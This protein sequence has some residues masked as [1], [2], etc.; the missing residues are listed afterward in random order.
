[1][2]FKK[3]SKDPEPEWKRRAAAARDV[4]RGAST[5]PKTERRLDQLEKALTNAADD[6]ERLR[7]AL[8]KM[9]PQRVT[10]ELK[11]ALR[12]RPTPTTPDDKL[13]TSL[14]RR[15]EAINTLQNREEVLGDLIESTLIDLETLAAGSVELAFLSDGDSSL[16]HELDQLHA[17]TSALAD[18]HRELD[19]L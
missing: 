11:G 3:R 2:I 7:E 1:M 9:A 13:I 14:R 8:T 6:Q 12:Q 19:Q 15:H 4:I 16:E 5:D 10:D 17:R 18:A